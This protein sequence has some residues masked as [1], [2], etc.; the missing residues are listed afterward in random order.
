MVGQPPE[1]SEG[2]GLMRAFSAIL[3]GLCLMATT[4][5]LEASEGVREAKF[6]LF[7]S[8]SE[9]SIRFYQGLGFE[10][11]QKEPNGY[12]TLRSGP[13]VVALSP[14]PTWLPLRW[15]SFMR[16]PPIGTEIV[17][18]SDHIEKLRATLE[19]EGHAPGPIRL[20][21]WGNQDF[22]VRDPDAY[23]VRVSEGRALPQSKDRP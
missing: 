18:Y 5:G 13:V 21:P 17:L 3:V 11:L 14:I 7:V 15:F 10:V 12:T 9:E 23:Y 16:S 8:D 19:A 22:R 20:Q 1:R 4:R 6:E 2:I